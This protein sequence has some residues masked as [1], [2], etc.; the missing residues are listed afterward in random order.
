MLAEERRGRWF[1]VCAP[2]V[3]WQDGCLMS[4]ESPRDLEGITAVSAL[5]RDVLTHLVS[6]VAPGVTTG[7]LDAEAARLVRRAGARSAPAA[8]YG[9]PRTEDRKS[10]RLN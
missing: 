1:A 9:F 5:V 7:A 10:T 4:I 3:S 6:R 2:A 8:V